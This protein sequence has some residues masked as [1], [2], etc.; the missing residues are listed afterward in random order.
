MNKLRQSGNADVC[1]FFILDDW[2][3]LNYFKNSKGY[4]AIISKK[5]YSGDRFVAADVKTQKVEDISILVL[6]SYQNKIITAFD[7]SFFDMIEKEN[8]EKLYSNFKN[9]DDINLINELKNSE[10]NPIICLFKIKSQ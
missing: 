8:L 4:T 5:D 9:I 3:Y 2:I 1:S 10:N 7:E 6:G